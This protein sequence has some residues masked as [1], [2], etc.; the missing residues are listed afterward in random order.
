M[1]HDLAS[2]RL[3]TSGLGDAVRADA[4]VHNYAIAIRASS[5]ATLLTDEVIG[6]AHII[7]LMV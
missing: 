7:F 1:I 4:M 3:H 2:L 5:L 6:E